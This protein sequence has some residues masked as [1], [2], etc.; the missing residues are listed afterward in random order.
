MT[1]DEGMQ[2]EFIV[3]TA[4]LD[5]WQRA[6]RRFPDAGVQINKGEAELIGN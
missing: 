1:V 3:N 4:I 6:K 5:G 2:G